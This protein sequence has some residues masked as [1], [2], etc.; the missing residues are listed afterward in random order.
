MLIFEVALGG[1][2]EEDLSSL[3]W[4]S[5]PLW[6]IHMFSVFFSIYITIL[7][8]APNLRNARPPDG[9]RKK[10]SKHKKGML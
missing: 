9:G 2:L 6:S 1:V 3:V 4:H 5:W 7:C 10:P 8:L